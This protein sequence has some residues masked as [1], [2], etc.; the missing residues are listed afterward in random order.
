M[1]EAAHEPFIIK[2]LPIILG[3]GGML[4]AALFYSRWKKLDPGIVTSRNDPVRKILLRRYYQNE[5]YTEWFAEKVVYGLALVSNVFDLKVVDGAVNKIS[6]LTV[7]FGGNVRQVQTGVIQNYITAIV[8]G[9]TVLL[10][11]IKLGMEVAI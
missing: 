8:L 2:I 5:I 9:L 6:K 1:H 3:V 4:I 11:V 10:V 7:G